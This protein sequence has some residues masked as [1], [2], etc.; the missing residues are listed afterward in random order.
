MKLLIL[1]GG[2]MAGSMMVGYFRGHENF[3]L[4]WT[5]RDGREDS[6][7]LDA[8]DLEA[9]RRLIGEAKPE[10]IVNCI[11]KLNQDAEEHPLEAY[12]VNGLLPHWLAFSA[13]EIGARLIHISSDCVFLGERGGYT[14][15]DPPDGV[16]VYARSKALGEVRDPQHLT[17]R[18]SIIG[19]DRSPKG[20]GLLQWFLGQ[21]GEVSGYSHVYWN[22]VTTLELAKAVE[23]AAGR[24]DIGG[25][26]HLLAA[27]PAS[28][29]DLLEWFKEAYGRDDISIVAAHEPMIDRTLSAVRRDWDYQAPSIPAMVQELAA[30]E[31]GR[32]G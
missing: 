17:I 31:Q 18:T 20:I 10:L 21:R 27:A 15:L 2:G 22:G 26:V 32:K 1:G 5:T 4:A 25:L 12:Q 14:E 7:P 28:K 11:G 6:L 13:S 16:T 24:A 30:W 29:L 3:E 9:V 23:F 19:P 8:S